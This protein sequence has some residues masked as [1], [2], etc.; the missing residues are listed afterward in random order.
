VYKWFDCLGRVVVLES[1]DIP[2]IPVWGLVL[3][4]PRRDDNPSIAMAEDGEDSGI[5]HTPGKIM[6]TLYLDGTITDNPNP[7]E[8]E[9]I[10]P[11]RRRSSSREGSCKNGD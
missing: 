1:G 8:N 3:L 7:P 10:R 6:G 9:C 2:T 11:G 4:V 5:T